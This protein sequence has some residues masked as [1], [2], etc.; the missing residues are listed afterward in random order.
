MQVLNEVPDD[1]PLKKWNSLVLEASIK[2]GRALNNVIHYKR[3]MQEAGFVDIREEK[4][5]IPTN[6]WAKDPHAKQVG[7]Y[8][9]ENLLQGVEGMSLKQ[10]TGSLGWSPEEVQVLLAGVRSNLKDRNIHAYNEM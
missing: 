9:R 4:F 10:F 2:R 7:L 1:L 3:W 5:F 8:N 6:P